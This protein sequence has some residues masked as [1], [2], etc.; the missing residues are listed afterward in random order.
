MKIKLYDYPP[1]LPLHY[2][3][4]NAT[5]EISAP[6]PCIGTQILAGDSHLNRSLGIRATGSQVPYKSLNIESRCLNTGRRSGSKVISP[7]LILEKPQ[8][9]QF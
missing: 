4:F 3:D 7:E 8:T 5:T 1:S 9:L 2:R 6:A